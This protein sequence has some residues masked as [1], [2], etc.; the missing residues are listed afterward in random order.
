MKRIIITLIQVFIVTLVYSQNSYYVSPTGNN[1]NNGSISTPWETI[2]YGVNQ[3]NPGDTLFIRGGTYQEKIDVDVSGMPSAYITIKNYQNENVVIDAINFSDDIPIIWTD[4]AYLHIEGLHLTNNIHNYAAGLALQGVAHDIEIINNKISNIKFSAD[5]NASVTTNTNAV[6]L[7]I[8]ADSAT[9]SIYNILIKGN[10]VFNNQ[11]GYSENISAGG[12]F[13]TFI[14]EDNIVHDNTNI[15][16]DI[17]GHYETVSIPALDQGRYGVIR[18]NI[19]Y[20]CNSSYSTAAGIYID[21]GRDIIVENNICYNNGYGGEIGCEKNGSTSNVTFRNNIFYG[22]HYAGMAI[23]GYDSSFTGIVLNSNVY[24]NTFYQNDTGNNYSG[25]LL[26]SKLENCNIE[27][28]IFYISAQNVFMYA[29]R[30]QTNLSLNYNLVYADDGES[31]IIIEGNFN[32]VGLYNFYNASGFGSN[33]IFGNPDFVDP[34]N[35]DFHIQSNSPAINSG[36]PNYIMS[37]GEVDIDGESR[38]IDS[39]IDCGADEFNSG[40]GIINTELQEM[41]IYPNPTKNIVFFKNLS[42]FSYKVYSIN[43][44]LIKTVDNQKHVDLSNLNKGLYFV[45]VYD[46][47]KEKTTT[48]KVIKK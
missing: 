37:S 46:N 4:N 15:G 40:L 30:T 36:N 17:G 2:Q 12:N 9:D 25:E 5:P 48:I 26:L 20:N 6:P 44:Q 18:N 35:N 24:N 43:G 47:K 3:L 38:I 45:K 16:I 33:S 27:N 14:I 7:S 22:N 41:T 28:N 11:T 32:S 29:Y 13:S 39:I 23:G 10:E 19:V 34:L 31:N 8:Y 1:S 21:G 42:N